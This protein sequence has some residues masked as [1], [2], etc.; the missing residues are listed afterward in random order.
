MPTTRTRKK[1]ARST[2]SA[3]KPE[4][5]LTLP[6]RWQDLTPGQLTRVFYLMAMQHLTGQDLTTRLLFEWAGY[7]PLAQH[8]ADRTLIESQDGYA[9]QYIVPTELLFMAA[10]TLDF[11]LRTDEFPPECRL[12]ECRCG[13][14]ALDPAL[15]TMT[16][17]DYIVADRA[18]RLY[19]ETRD[20]AA[21]ERLC[22][23]LY[24]L[25]ADKRAQAEPWWTSAEIL[26]TV[27]WF[28]AV[29]R[30]FAREWPDLLKPVAEPSGTKKHK[31]F[32]ARAHQ[33]EADAMIRALT[34]GDIT[35]EPGVLRA[36]VWRCLTELNA[37][38]REA[39]LLRETK[40]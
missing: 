32:D 39:R 4:L 14:R 36:S 3:K 22:A 1:T 9:R 24:P 40:R 11:V 12:A 34:G 2:S 16:F 19:A 17:G 6:E 37:K 7:K 30:G 5:R 26:Q 21:A 8:D 29:K 10:R 35:K 18:H 23:L 33:E 25:P 38:A 15:R 13:R 28:S 20:A 27:V 31:P